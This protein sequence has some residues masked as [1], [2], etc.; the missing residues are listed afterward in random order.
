MATLI[1]PQLNINGSS[2]RDLIDP[3]QQAW[4]LIDDVVEAL[5]QVTPNGR[6]YPGNA[7]ACTADRELHYDRIKALREL[8][9]WLLAEALA[10]QDQEG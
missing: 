10:I 2:A 3:R 9:G 6:D 8:Q 4:K 5:A 7:V 1:T